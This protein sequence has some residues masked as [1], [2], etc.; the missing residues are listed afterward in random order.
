MTA[1]T[2]PVSSVASAAVAA[3][4][5]GAVA[6]NSGVGQPLAFEKMANYRRKKR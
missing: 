6:E 5:S 3:I 2:A 1:Q 4:Y